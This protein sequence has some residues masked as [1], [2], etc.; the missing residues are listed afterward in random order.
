MLP[1]GWRLVDLYDVWLGAPAAGRPGRAA[2]YRIDAGGADA[3]R[4]TRSSGSAAL[5]AADRAPAGA[6]KGGDDRAA[7]TCGRSL[8]DVRAWS[9][10]AR[11]WSSASGRGST[12]CS[13]TG[14]PEEVVAALGD[15]LGPARGGRSVVRERLLAGR[16]S[17]MTS[18]LAPHD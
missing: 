7:T 16:T 6:P 9:T 3:T 14:R 12:R 5:L 10:R 11:P 18:G 17:S 1:E 13:G 8:V 4:T 15:A 2:D